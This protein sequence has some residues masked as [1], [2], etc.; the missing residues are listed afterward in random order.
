[1]KTNIPRQSIYTH[2]GGKAKH[3][4][5]EQQLRRS[6]MACLLW[7]DSFYEDGV[8]I[9]ERVCN[10][11]PQIDPAK[12]ASI[13]IEAREKM[14]LRHVPLLIVREM[15]R[16][17]THKMFVSDTLSRV[18]QRA[19]ELAEILSLYWKEGR[20]PISAQIKKGI[21]R[22]FPK[23]SAYQLSKYDRPAKI[24]LKDAL[25]LSHAKPKDGNQ[26][27]VWKKLITG[28]IEPAITW[29]Y[30]L[31]DTTDGLTKKEKW[32]KVIDM[33]FAD[34]KVRN[35]LAIL[36]NLRNISEVDVSAYHMDK[37]IGCFKSPSWTASQV[38]P[39]RFVAAA[40]HVPQWES[41]IE[42]AMLSSIS[43]SDR[44]E[45]YTVL[46]VDVSRSMEDPL[47]RKSDL[48]RMDAACGLAILLREIC[49]KVS[50]FTF[51]NEFVQIP[52]RSGF[53]LR[54]VIV[55]SQPHSST[56]LGIAIRAIYENKGGDVRFNNYYFEGKTT[57]LGQGLRPSRLIVITDEQS[58][59]SIPDPVGKGYMINVSLEKNGVG[60]GSWL[61]IDGFSEAIVNYLLEYEKSENG[62]TQRKQE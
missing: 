21:A 14:H 45:G 22:A 27:E 6:V 7:E 54:D 1:M 4:N 56:P 58:C 33:W 41:F 55:D 9:A 38:L 53:A 30:I 57:Y 3:I 59:D 39:F 15:A 61:H 8:A 28:T 19:D 40:K 11:I 13:A 24:K 43:Q 46:L 62:E 50:I 35:H 51:S 18:I 10:L 44:L 5:A 37:L 25:F 12:V 16:Y 34:G 29:E 31:S 48:S 17:K 52:P 23:F 20:C 60:Y 2:E 47:S 42:K 49:D 32:E 26:E 36:R